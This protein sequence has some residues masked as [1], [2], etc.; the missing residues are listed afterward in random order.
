MR[1]LTVR[2]IIDMIDSGELN[3]NQSTQRKFVYASIDKVKIAGVD[4][5]KAQTFETTK[6]GSLLYSVLY[7]RIQLPAVFFWKNTETGQ[8]NIHDG[9]QRIL[10]FYYFVKGDQVNKI[11]VPVAGNKQNAFS[12]L[13][14]DEQE[15]LLDYTFDVVEREGNSA[16]E[17]LSFYRINTNA[18]PLTD[19]EVISGCF[20]GTFLTGFESYLESMAKT[21]DVIQVIGRGN[22]AYKFLSILFNAIG[23]NG[24]EIKT[25]CLDTI[26]QEVKKVRSNCFKAENYEFNKLLN[27]FAKLSKVGGTAKKCPFSEDMALLLARYVMKHDW[28]IEKVI[29]YYN[30]KLHLANDINHWD[31]A[32]HKEFLGAKFNHGVELCGKR[33]FS[34]ETKDLLYEKFGGCQHIDDEGIQCRETNYS[35]L[36]VDHITPW[37]EG[38]QTVIDNAQLLCKQHNSSKGKKI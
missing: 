36:E 30:T 20:H 1:Q 26:S 7:N 13:D 17:E 27:Y 29:C 10:T 21:Y 38:G 3:T 2:Q 16:E 23:N 6:S 25:K 19:Y 18:L 4:P 34:K 35:K 8:L 31:Y 9:K 15:Y 28:D 14:P 5:S 24:F 12:D 11:L 33:F 32:T 37:A 22:Q